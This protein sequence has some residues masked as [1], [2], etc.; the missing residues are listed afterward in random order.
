MECGG[1]DGTLHGDHF[2]LFSVLYVRDFDGGSTV[3]KI[4]GG[5]LLFGTAVKNIFVVS[6]YPIL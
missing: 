6:G 2:S 5:L 1:G 3:L 4:F